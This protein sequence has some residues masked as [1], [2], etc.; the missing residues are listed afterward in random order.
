MAYDNIFYEVSGRVAT[1]TLNR[2]EVMNAMVPEA[3]VRMNK[4]VI[5]MGL[6]AAGMYSG[7]LLNGPLSALAHSSHG[8]ERERLNQAQAQG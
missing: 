7:M 5:M 3:S 8:P 6:M 4:E 1:I 2:P